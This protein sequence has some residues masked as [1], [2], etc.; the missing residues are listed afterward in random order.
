MA[1]ETVHGKT[2]GCTALVADP[3]GQ[4]MGQGCEPQIL[5]MHYAWGQQSGLKVMHPC[6]LW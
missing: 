1:G 6:A 5:T 3:L 2:N 4:A